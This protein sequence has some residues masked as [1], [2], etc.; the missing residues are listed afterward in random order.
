MNDDDSE[1]FYFN[2]TAFGSSYQLV[3]EDKKRLIADGAEVV[4]YSS[5]G[6]KH[7]TNALNSDCVHSGYIS[8]QANSRVALTSCNGLVGCSYLISELFT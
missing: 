2:I 3:L 4:W 7:Q 1:Q 5:N 6:V 8:R